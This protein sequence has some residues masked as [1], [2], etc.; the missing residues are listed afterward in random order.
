MAINY[1]EKMIEELSAIEGLDLASAKAFGE[2]H[3]IPVR[4]VIAKAKALGLSYKSK[5]GT[6][7]EPKGDKRTKGDV[8]ASI[9]EALGLEL[10]S[11]SKM[12]M[13]DLEALEAKVA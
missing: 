5:D 8:I 9:Q 3:D 1:T 7:A 13:V 4:S 12:T 10:A 11:F 2:K 6:K